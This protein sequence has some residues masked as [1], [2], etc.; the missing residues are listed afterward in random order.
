MDSA[1]PW[2]SGVP[3]DKQFNRLL[4]SG[5][6]LFI[7]LA[8][9]FPYL[10]VN[11]NTKPVEIEKERTQYTR[12]IIEEKKLPPPPVIEKQKPEPEPIQKKPT[13]K[14][15]PVVKAKPKPLPAKKAE[16]VKP[17]ENL[18]KARETAKKSGVLALADELAAMRQSV[19]VRKMKNS[20]L[21][22][23]SS[24]AAKPTRKLLTSTES[25]KVGGISSTSLSQDTAGAALSGRETTSI[26]ATQFAANQQD[27][28]QQAGNAS[29]PMGG[30]SAESVRRVMD[31]N[32]GAIFAVYNRALRKDPG[33]E[34][35][36]SFSMVIE[37]SGAVTLVDLVASELTDDALVKKILS[38]IK[39]INFGNEPVDQT[40]VNY[41]FDFLPS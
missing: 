37:S 25:A 21:S 26:A 32:K 36:L 10:P 30:R 18:H 7:V 15:K 1:L 22:R 17:V 23:G 5:F 31:A 34:G 16:P 40:R 6:I 35:K 39:L 38:R 28:G 2:A 41:S 33:L 29:Q 12:L 8:L 20:S 14:P 3:E 4:L 13:V 19:D 27:D 24:E 11:K 9:V